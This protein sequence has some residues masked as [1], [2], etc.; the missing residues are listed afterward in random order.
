MCI[1]DSPYVSGMIFFADGWYLA[2]NPYAA[3]G[4]YINRMSDY[5]QGCTYKVSKKNGP[6]A[7]PF[8]YLYWDFFIRNTDKL[9]GNA[10]LSHSYRTLGKMSD[11]KIKAI[12]HDTQRFLTEIKDARQA[13][14]QKKEEGNTK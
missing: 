10:R 13:A 5:C 4:S 3:S 11:D 6:D 7:C 9:K 1:R 14:Q 12:R 2:S 8:N